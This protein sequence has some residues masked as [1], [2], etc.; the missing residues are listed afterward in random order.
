MQEYLLFLDRFKDLDD[1][2]FIVGDIYTF[3]DFAVFSP[4]N[5][6]NNLIVILITKYGKR[7]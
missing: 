1:A 3:K 5:F 4:P 2:S 7:I 6:S